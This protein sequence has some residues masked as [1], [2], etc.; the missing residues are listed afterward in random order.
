MQSPTFP[1]L[2]PDLGTWSSVRVGRHAGFDRVVHQ[3]EGRGRPHYAVRYVDEPIAD[4]SGEPVHVAGR[5]WLEVYVSSIGYP[6]VDGNSECPER[7]A[8][9]LRG[10]VFAAAP[11]I[12]GGFEALAQT[13]VGLDRQ[14]P[15]RVLVLTNPSRLVIDVRTG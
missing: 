1:E 2:G 12:C 6:G 11:S 13:F 14:R 15:F 3:F 7:S 4:P 10:T 8:P 5:A 9:D